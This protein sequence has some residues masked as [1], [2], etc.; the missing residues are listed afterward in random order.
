MKNVMV[1]LETLGTKPGS[2]ILSI[3]AVFFS[4]EGLGEEFYCIVNHAD[5]VAAG[6]TEDASTLKWWQSQKPEAQK[7]LSDAKNEVIAKPL[8]EALVLFSKWL[9]GEAG[10]KHLKVWGNGSDFD[11]VL[12]SSAFA[13]VGM[14]TPWLFWNSR[15]FRTLKNLPGAELL[16][17]KR[18]GTHHNALDD[19]KT[20]A[21]HAVEIMQRVNIG[22]VY[23]A[24]SGEKVRS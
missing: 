2:V 13:V 11:N 16:A 1:D 7:V 21:L 8:R 18:V 6:L 4:E 23:A 22:T 19:A 14:A 24:E 9:Y 3:G 15:C 12:L 20:Q 10:K 5:S 17:P